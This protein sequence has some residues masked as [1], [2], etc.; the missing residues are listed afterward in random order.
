MDVLKHCGILRN[1]IVLSINDMINAF[2]ATGQL[3]VGTDSTYN[4]HLANL[5]CDQKAEEDVQQGDC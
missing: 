1:N 3:I 2:V 5:A 4:M